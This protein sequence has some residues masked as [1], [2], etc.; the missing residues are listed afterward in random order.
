MPDIEWSPARRV[1]L[2]FATVYFLLYLFPFPLTAVPGAE[3]L[4]RWWDAGWAVVVKWAGLHLFGVTITVMPNGSGDTTFNYVQV[5]CFLVA[6]L[7]ATAIWSALDRRPRSYDVLYHWMRSYVRFCLAGMMFLYGAAK[8]IQS[9]FPPPTIDRLLQ[10][11]GEASPMGL[12]WTFMGASAAYNVFTGL[13]EIIGGLLLTARRTTT[14]G[15]LVCIAVMSNVAMLNFAY[16]VPAKL[17]S[18]HLLAMAVFLLLPNLRRLA[19]VFVLNRP[20]EA[21]E[22]RPQLGERWRR[23]APVARTAFVLLL[24]IPPFVQARSYRSMAGK[25]SPFY[26]IWNVEELAIDGRPHPLVP[27]DA[28]GWRRVVFEYPTT[29][30]VQFLSDRRQRFLLKLDEAKRTM[31]LSRGSEPGKTYVMAYR[32]LSPDTMTLEGQLDGKQ[33]RAR[34]HLTAM[35]SFLLTTRGFHWIN[36]YPYNR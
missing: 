22:L 35:P 29:V 13:G 19:N 27:G 26:G 36:E 30:G 10:P 6:A 28:V 16:D 15:A 8:V 5:F 25:R 33:L 11:F 1:A 34:L 21:A 18:L 31:S 14:L 4:F 24:L 23:W 12:L 32:V 9:Q 17:F 3:A 20:A 2:R 7:L